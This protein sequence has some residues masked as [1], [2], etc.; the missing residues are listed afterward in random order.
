MQK[1]QVSETAGRRISDRKDIQ[2]IHE[3]GNSTITNSISNATT[4][5]T[6]TNTTTGVSTA[7]NAKM[8][9]HLLHFFK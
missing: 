1:V 5:I 3:D 7:N 6:A 8:H 4:D 2:R 9:L